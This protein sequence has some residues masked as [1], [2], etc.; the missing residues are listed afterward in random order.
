MSLTNAANL[1]DFSETAL[2]NIFRGKSWTA[3]AN[4]V[5]YA[6]LLKSVANIDQGTTGGTND[7]TEFTTADFSNY[8]R[9]PVG[10]TTPSGALTAGAPSGAGNIDS[11]THAYVVTFGNSVGDSLPGPASNVITASAGNQQ[12]ALTAIPTGPSGT[13]DR[14]V[15]RSKAGTGASGPFYLL[16]TLNDN[17]TTTY[18]DNT[19]DSGL[20]AVAPT[21]NTSGWGSIAAAA[22]VSPSDATTGQEL[23]N[24]VQIPMSGTAWTNNSAGSISVAGIGLYD[25][26]SGGNM[27]SYYSLTSV[28]TVNASTGIQ[29]N[30]FSGGQGYIVACD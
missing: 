19:A 26:P 11:G 14:K 21:V 5:V 30:A 15:W 23:K 12:S 18:T 28:Q 6:G 27:L 9:V 16:T 13:T 4:G 24:G 20:G 3:P 7:G 1:S 8:A 22:D 10:L 29:F 25:S 2:L 17:T